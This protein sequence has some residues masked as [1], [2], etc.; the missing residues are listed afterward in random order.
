VTIKITTVNS[1]YYLVS[2]GDELVN[3][4]NKSTT[5]I[6]PQQSVQGRVL[7]IS[8]KNTVVVHVNNTETKI[9]NCC[10]QFIFVD[11]QWLPLNH[12]TT[13]KS[14]INKLLT[15]LKN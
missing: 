10:Q 2:G 6:L 4:T 7:Y 3:A 8:S 13:V 9:K 12:K 15:T 1:P 11:D 5:I 14:F